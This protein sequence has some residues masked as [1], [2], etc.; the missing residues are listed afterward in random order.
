MVQGLT[1][2]PD[3]RARLARELDR[4]RATAFAWGQQDCVLGLAAG[5][6]QAMTGEDLARAWRGRYR[7]AAGALRALRE[8]G[9]PGLGAALADHL[10]EIS[11]DYADIGDLALVATDAPPGEALAIFDASGLI[12]MTEQGHGRI[13]RTHALR[14][15]KIG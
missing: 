2:L 5:A 4:Q 8:A 1:R 10:P 7:S 12:A 11:P 14:A 15:F 3:W 6:V 13:A 9:Y